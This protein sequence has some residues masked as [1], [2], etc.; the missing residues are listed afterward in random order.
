MTPPLRLPSLAQRHAELKALLWPES[1]LVL[2]QGRELRFEFKVSP[3]PIARVYRCL[4]KVY[5]SKFPELLV[6]DPDLKTVAEGRVL[7]HVYPHVGRGTKL[8]LWLPRTQ[9]WSAQMRLS[10]T[11]LPWAAEWLDYFEEWLVTDVWAGG[12]VHPEPKS[13]RWAR[14]PPPLRNAPCT[15]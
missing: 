6:M 2:L 4:L 14:K 5:P 13:R 10:D 15:Y 11:Y 1:R 7:P 8:C 9:E 3:T 12:G